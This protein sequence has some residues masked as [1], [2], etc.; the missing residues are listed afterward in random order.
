VPPQYKAL[1]SVLVLIVGT[2]LFYVDTRAGGGAARWVALALGPAMVAAIWMFPEPK[3]K[4]ARR[5]PPAPR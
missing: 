2:L 1:I 5:D 4:A 3:S